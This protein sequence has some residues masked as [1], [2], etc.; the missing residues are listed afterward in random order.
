MIQNEQPPHNVLDTNSYKISTD[1]IGLICTYL[2]G[3]LQIIFIVGI[4][5]LNLFMNYFLNN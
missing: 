5:I 4:C 3:F 2:K 1:I